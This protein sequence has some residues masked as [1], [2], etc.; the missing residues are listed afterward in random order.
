MRLLLVA[1]D[2]ADTRSALMR[3]LSESGYSVAEAADAATA[4]EIVRSRRP[5]LVVLDYGLPLPSD[6]ENF[7]RAKKADANIASI[8]VVL[9][10]GYE[11]PSEM[12]GTVAI[13]HKPFSEEEILAAI[14]TVLDPPEKPSTNAA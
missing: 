3:V 14:S 8:P 6:G 12:D 7:L 9:I 4:L 1:E 13:V 2:D 11:L 10:S 5:D